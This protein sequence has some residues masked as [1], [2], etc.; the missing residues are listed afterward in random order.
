MTEWPRPEPLPD[1]A[2]PTGARW[3]EKLLHRRFVEV[4]LSDETHRSVYFKPTTT[5][6]KPSRLHSLDLVVVDNWL[7]ASDTHP[8]G[9]KP[10]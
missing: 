2:G 3:S 7:P 4:Q 1:K 5:L 8:G 10:A 6:T 9:V